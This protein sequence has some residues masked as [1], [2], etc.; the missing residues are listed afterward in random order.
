MELKRST[1][2]KKKNS[3]QKFMK[4]NSEMT[5]KVVNSVMDLKDSPGTLSL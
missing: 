5:L 2:S 1:N 3:G 4:L